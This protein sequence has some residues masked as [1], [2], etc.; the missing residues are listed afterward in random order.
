MERDFLGA[1][2]EVPVQNLVRARREMLEILLRVFQARDDV[3]DAVRH[4]GGYSRVSAEY[5]GPDAS[6]AIQKRISIQTV[7]RTQGALS[8]DLTNR[9]SATNSTTSGF[10][11]GWY[12]TQ[13]VA[14]GQ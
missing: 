4:S 11:S 5:L 6:R 14:F 1:L 12:T 7:R 8:T 10:S 9:S 13:I 2:V 3:M